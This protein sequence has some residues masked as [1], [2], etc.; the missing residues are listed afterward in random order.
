MKNSGGGHI[1][2]SNTDYVEIEMMTLDE[3]VLRNN[4]SNIKFIKIDVE[5]YEPFVFEGAKKTIESFLPEL[6]FE[7]TEKWH[8][9]YGKS[10]QEIFDFLIA[11]NY[12]FYHFDSIINK[13]VSCHDPYELYKK[14]VQL[15][16]YAIQ[17][18]Q[19]QAIGNRDLRAQKNKKL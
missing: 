7:I 17:K 16:F 19:L 15:N 10:A 18:R 12:E 5:G 1:E 3:F 6:Y 9:Q 4:L 14:N 8:N 11:L 2:I 13:I